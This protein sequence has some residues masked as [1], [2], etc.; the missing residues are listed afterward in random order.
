MN[1]NVNQIWETASPQQ[2]AQVLAQITDR[3]TIESF[4]RD[5]MTEKEII[6]ISS[7]LEAA[8]MLSDGKKYTEII[9]TTKLSSRTIAR[10]SDWMQNG[11]GGYKTALS[12]IDVHH[13]HLPPARAE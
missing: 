11:R 6:E 12:L 3:Q 8:K 4:L 2:F 13:T 7:R 10:I 1:N 5:V 9:E